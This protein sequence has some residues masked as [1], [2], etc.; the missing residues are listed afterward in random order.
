[1]MRLKSRSVQKV[2]SGLV[3]VSFL[4]TEVMWALPR[5]FSRSDLENHRNRF[6]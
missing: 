4:Y 5:D 1:M 6:Q 2:V 3:V